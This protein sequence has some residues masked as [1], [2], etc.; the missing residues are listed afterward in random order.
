M[1]KRQVLPAP[2][3]TD[4]QQ[5]LFQ[6]AEIQSGRFPDLRW[7]H[8]I[9]NGGHRN[10]ATA[11]RL[12]AE[13]VKPGVPDIFLPAVRGCFHGLYV[14]MKRTEGGRLSAKQKEWAVALSAR[15]YC[16]AKCEGWEDAAR[17]ILHYLRLEARR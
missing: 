2:L 17:T 10:K 13:G 3:E 1:G 8:A 15:G 11:G 16:V 14:E 7:M 12:K 4:E 6:W 9:P 5:A